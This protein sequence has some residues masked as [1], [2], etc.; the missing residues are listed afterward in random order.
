MTAFDE[1]PIVHQSFAVIDQIVGAHSL[2]PDVYAVLRR[3]IHSTADFEFQSLLQC[4][5]TAIATAI[6]ALSQRCPIITDVGMV[7]QGI[8]R[9]VTHTFGNPVIVAVDQASQARPG[10]TR[11]ETGLLHCCRIYPK[12]LYVI[13]N[14]PTALLALCR[15]I[16]QGSVQ[17]ALIVGAPV[18]FINVIEAKQALA[19]LAVPQIRVDGRKGGSAVAAA[20]VNALLILAWEWRAPLPG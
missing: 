2:S 14:A 15:Q 12:G 16:A 3:V 8:H 17:P 4:S 18:G 13:G 6:T 11:T 10:E 19:Q 20:I 5:E 1:H 9:V 7:A